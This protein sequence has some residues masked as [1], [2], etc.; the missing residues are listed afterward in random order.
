MLV[1]SA[2]DLNSLRVP[3][4]LCTDLRHAAPKAVLRFEAWLN[5]HGAALIR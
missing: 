2:D 3:A 1:D 5:K 4:T